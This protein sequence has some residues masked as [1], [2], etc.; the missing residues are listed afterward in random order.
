M[1]MHG[2]SDGAENVANTGGINS[3][4]SS[5][6]RSPKISLPID[7]SKILRARELEQRGKVIYRETPSKSHSRTPKKIGVGSN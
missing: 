5:L 1:A 2:Y 7:L 4:T 3:K 6:E